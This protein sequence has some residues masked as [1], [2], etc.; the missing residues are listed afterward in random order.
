MS[1][2]TLILEDEGGDEKQ[3]AMKLIFEGGFD[4]KSPAHQHAQ[5]LVQLMDQMFASKQDAAIV[6]VMEESRIIT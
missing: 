5:I 1:R 2:A 6:P 4:P 3:V